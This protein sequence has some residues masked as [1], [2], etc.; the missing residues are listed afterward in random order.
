MSKAAI[1]LNKPKPQPDVTLETMGCLRPA[2]VRSIDRGEEFVVIAVYTTLGANGRTFICLQDGRDPMW[3][4]SPEKYKFVRY[5]EKDESVTIT[6]G[7][8]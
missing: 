1:T 5:L 6:G 8:Y 7:G 2:L 4:S 3:I